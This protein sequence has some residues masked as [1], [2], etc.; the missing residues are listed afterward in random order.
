MMLK[1][2]KKNGVVCFK[3]NEIEISF[4]E[5]PFKQKKV[6]SIKE[7]DGVPLENDSK[8]MGMSEEEILFWSSQ[9]AGL[10][11]KPNA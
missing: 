9:D 2:L 5:T 3:N 7:L 8:Y 10:E 1:L 6:K 11:S 4:G